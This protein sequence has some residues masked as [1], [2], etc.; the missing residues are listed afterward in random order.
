MCG[1]ERERQDGF[2]GCTEGTEV[3]V[4]KVRQAYSG[5]IRKGR[6]IAQSRRPGTLHP[7]NTKVNL[8]VSKGTRKR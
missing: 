4:G 5:R 8:T 1:P 3:A 2:E 7:R 6:V